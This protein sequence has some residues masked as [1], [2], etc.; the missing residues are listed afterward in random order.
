M[1]RQAFEPLQ[2]AI[3]YNEVTG[4]GKGNAGGDDDDEIENNDDIAEVNV[5]YPLPIID[6]NFDVKD[7]EDVTNV[8]TVDANIEGN[9][10]EN[11]NK[12]SSNTIASNGKKFVGRDDNIGLTTVTFTVYNAQGIATDEGI[13]KSY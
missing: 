7:V 3:D 6:V 9:M 8:P 2:R 10:N 5:P 11:S 13:E 4:F 1:H 12:N